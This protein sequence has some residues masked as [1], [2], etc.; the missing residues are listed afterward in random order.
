MDETGTMLNHRAFTEPFGK[1]ISLASIFTA[2]QTGILPHA[3]LILEIRGGKG[4][5][6]LITLRN[7][8]FKPHKKRIDS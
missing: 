5:E 4:P 6:S 3:P 7:C 1:L 2:W 8:F